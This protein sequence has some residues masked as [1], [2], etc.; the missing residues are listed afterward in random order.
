MFDFSN[1]IHSDVL[2]MGVCKFSEL[3]DALI[4]CRALARIPQNSKSVIVVLF[5]YYLGEEYY[6][7]LNI[8]KYAV[9]TDYHEICIR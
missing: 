5:P 3:Q 8:S 7:K 1:I 2:P 9:P 6:E 4:P